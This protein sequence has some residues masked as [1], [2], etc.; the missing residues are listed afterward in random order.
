MGTHHRRLTQARAGLGPNASRRGSGRGMGRESYQP[1]HAF[2]TQ[3]R[4]THTHIK[5]AEG[6]L[7]GIGNRGWGG[8]G[9]AFAHALDAER[10]ARGRIL[11][12]ND[13]DLWYLGSARQQIVHQRPGKELAVLVID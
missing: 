11:E 12:M 7:H 10:I 9:T 6:I 1:A 5:R 3:W 13:L 8:N 4:L 2:R